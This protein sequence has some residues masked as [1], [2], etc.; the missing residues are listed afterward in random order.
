MNKLKEKQLEG[1]TVELSKDQIAKAIEDAKKLSNNPNQNQFDS[2]MNWES[3][4]E[5]FKV[6]PPSS[7]EDAVSRIIELCVDN[8]ASN[9]QKHLISEVMLNNPNIVSVL[10]AFVK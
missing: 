4:L 9:E 2:V 5:A 6:N 10:K 8:K 3:Q 7:L 1:D